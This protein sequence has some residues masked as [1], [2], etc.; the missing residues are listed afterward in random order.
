MIKD[1]K[2]NTRIK[3]AFL[4]S[5]ATKG[6]STAGL[7]YL[8]I[9]LQDASGTIE[10]KK[11]DVNDA[12]YA[13][14]VTGNIVEVTGD[15]L[16]YRNML[17]IKLISGLPKSMDEIDVSRFVS[18]APVAPDVLWTRFGAYLD[19]L[20]HPDVRAIT[21][22][23]I[24]EHRDDFMIYPAASKNHHE[25]ASGLL[26]HVVC[27]LDLADDISKRY[28]S[29]DTDLLFAG[30]ILHDLGKTVELSGPIIPKY[31]VQ[32]RLLGHISI[33]QGWIQEI[34]KRLEI[35]S[36]V[37]VLL[38]HLILSHHGKPEFGSPQV[39]QI[40]EA[41]VIHYIDNLDA[42]I[43]MMEKALEGVTPGE[44]TT[45]VWSLEDRSFYKPKYK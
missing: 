5:N 29:L 35:T 44:F 27:M 12:D 37:P 45:R 26:Y 23:L 2:E 13:L 7:P 9:T 33:C 20:V 38:Q 8:N 14:F 28:P 17:Q 22:A 10:A 16:S 24:E 21:T 40:R 43:F 19:R 34:A 1:L 30:I 18:A 3:E 11:W 39:P 31:T 15:V 32:G 42:R 6:V 36:E 41:E 25:F 4:I